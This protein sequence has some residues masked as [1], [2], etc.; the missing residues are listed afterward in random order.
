MKK[1]NSFF[2]KTSCVL[3]S[4]LFSLYTLNAQQTITLTDP[5]VASVAVT[6][7][8]IDID[9]AAIAL[10]RSSNSEVLNFAKTMTK[11]HQAVIGQAVELA[12][13]LNVTPKTNDLTKKLLSDAAKTK[14]QLNAAKAGA[15]DKAYVNNEVAYHKAVIDAVEK[16]LIPETENAELKSL[17][18]GILPALKTHLSHAEMLQKTLNK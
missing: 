1:G 2:L 11:D 7:N 8:Q 14:K 18:Q 10:K 6:A 12:K 13:K 17:L 4:G 3:I 16:V 5:E 15:F 9:Y